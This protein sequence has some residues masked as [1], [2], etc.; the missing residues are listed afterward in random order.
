MSVCAY[1]CVYVRAYMRARVYASERI[2]RGGSEGGGFPARPPARSGGRGG[3]G[4]CGRAGSQSS[5]AGSGSRHQ[6]V[7]G[8]GREL[9][10]PSA[11]CWS[12]CARA[13]APHAPLFTSACHVPARAT[14]CLLA[15]RPAPPAACV[16]ARSGISI[17]SPI[18]T[19]LIGFDHC[20]RKVVICL[21][22]GG[23]PGS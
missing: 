22:L 18:S 12:V 10:C 14:P 2:C 5:W 3:R 6:C 16:G 17:K 11:L 9:R 1:M 20:Q 8:C 13:A 23:N 4:A 15:P 21:P 7:A 19:L